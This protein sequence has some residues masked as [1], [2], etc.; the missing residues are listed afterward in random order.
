MIKREIPRLGLFGTFSRY[1]VDGKCLEPFGF[2]WVC[3][4]KLETG[5]S[6]L[7]AR[8]L[9][10]RYPHVPF[11]SAVCRLPSTRLPPAV[12]C[13]PFA[14]RTPSPGPRP[15]GPGTSLENYRVPKDGCQEKYLA[16]RYP[17]PTPRTAVCAGPSG[18]VITF[19]AGS[20]SQ[21]FGVRGTKGQEP[22]TLGNRSALHLLER[23]AQLVGECPGALGGRSITLRPLA[24]FLGL[25]RFHDCFRAQADAPT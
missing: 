15:I 10:Q 9:M 5:S 8:S 2:L 25:A 19:P 3:V 16:D 24:H 17:L 1:V 12:C 11:P 6:K 14:A 7:A 21:G 20:W 18:W 4:T 22:R 23:R 13:L